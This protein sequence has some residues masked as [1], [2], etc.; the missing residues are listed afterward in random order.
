M[1]LLESSP[2]E[3]AQTYAPYGAQGVLLPRPEGSFLLE[4][5][6]GELVLYLFDRCGPYLGTGPA[7]AVIHGLADLSQTGLMEPQPEPWAEAVGRSG[8]R[9][10]GQVVAQTWR[11]TVLDVG[12]PIVLSRPARPP[13]PAGAW[14]LEAEVGD[15]LHFETLPP[16]HGYLV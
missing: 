12:L 10:V 6:C 3:F 4:F 14:A 1:D 13:Y 9:G 5:V 11:A 2:A 7:R 8:L 16:L 15:W